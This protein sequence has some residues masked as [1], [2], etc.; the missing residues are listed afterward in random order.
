MSRTS[1]K[2]LSAMT[3]I[4]RLSRSAC[5]CT[6]ARQ[7]LQKMECRKVEN[8]VNRIEAQGID[9]KFRYPKE[10]IFNKEPPDFVAVRPV[11]ID[12]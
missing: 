3:W 9:A 1:F 6:A 2:S 11:K 8:P 7:F 12:G 5:S 10:R 4:R